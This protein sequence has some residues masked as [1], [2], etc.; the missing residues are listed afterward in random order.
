MADNF[1]F[2]QGINYKLAGSGCIATAT[3]II[4]SSFKLPD[5]TLITM[6]MFGDTV[7][8]TQEPGTSKEEN[9]SFTGVTQNANGTATLT[10]V[11][12]GLG[13][14]APYTTD[15]ALKLAHAGGTILIISNSAPFYNELSAKD[16]DETITSQYTF[17]DPKIP[18]MDVYSAPT[19]DTQFA[20]KKYVDDIASGGTTSINRIVVAGTAG[21]TVAAGEVV[22]FDTTDKEWKLADGS[23][24][25]TCDNVLL[26]IAQGAGTNGNIISGGVLLEG[27]DSNQTGFTAG[28]TLYISD[29]AGTI[30]SSA[31]TIS[32][33]VGYAKSATEIYFKVDTNDLLRADGAITRTA[34]GVGI[35]LEDTDPGLEINSNKLDVKVKAAGGIVKDSDGLSVDSSLYAPTYSTFVAG[36]NITAGQPV[37]L[38]YYFPNGNITL[39]T[40]LGWTGTGTNS[41]SISQAFTVGNNTN[42]VLVV[43]IRFAGSSVS[44]GSVQY[45]AQTMSLVQSAVISGLANYTNMYVLFN[46]TAGTA[47]ITATLTAATSITYVANAYS[48][49]NVAQTIDGSAKADTAKTV[50]YTPTNTGV[51]CLGAVGGDATDFGEVVNMNTERLYTRNGVSFAIVSGAS[52]NIFPKKQITLSATNGSNVGSVVVGLTPYNTITYGAVIKSSSAT[53]PNSNE[54]D[55]YTTFCGFATE[56]KNA[57]EN[58]LVQREGVITGLSSLLQLSPYYLADTVGT[59]SSAAGTNSKKI[60]VAI[61]DTQL[62]IR[63][64]N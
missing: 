47:N 30:A 58:I 63:Q 11:V 16:N 18:V 3:E 21:E 37:S 2:L 51:L 61:S 62:F 52:G 34:D 24:V 19:D 14:V 10:G 7:Y 22:Y 32:K 35:N 53:L 9:G 42:K 6:D 1:K 57:G 23:S 59:I 29:T 17:T 55:K 20:T 4:L 12:K 26:G 28:D 13:F 54:V 31:G 56:S 33:K 50:N 41:L 8:F 64:D 38:G 43:F 44:I 48:Y 25:A 46:P 45:G 39:D 15:S 49:Y 5:G 36:E 60:G 27:L 40:K